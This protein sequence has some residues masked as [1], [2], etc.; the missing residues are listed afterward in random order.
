MSHLSTASIFT[1]KTTIHFSTWI[2]EHSN[3]SPY[4]ASILRLDTGDCGIQVDI[5]PE[6]LHALKAAI[7]QHLY[8]ISYVQQELKALQGDA[9]EVQP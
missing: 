4:V 6:H 1:D 3:R 7:D 8:N 9:Q 5:E 2:V